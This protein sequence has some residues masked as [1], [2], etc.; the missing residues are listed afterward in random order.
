MASVPAPPKERCG[1]GRSHLAR[2]PSSRTAARTRTC[3]SSRL[4]TL[5]TRARARASARAASTSTPCSR[6]REAQRITRRTLTTLSARCYGREP[7]CWGTTP[8]SQTW[9]AGCAAAS[10][11]G[12]LRKRN[13][14]SV[15]EGS[16][17]ATACPRAAP[18]AAANAAA[19]VARRDPAAN[20]PAARSRSRG[21][22]RRARLRR[23]A[24]PPTMASSFV[25]PRSLAYATDFNRVYKDGSTGLKILLERHVRCWGMG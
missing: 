7:S 24:R 8:S 17:A 6:S 20:V 9:R 5:G 4:P 25:R 19:A 12:Y 13:R 18:R 22:A 10:T 15:T 21:P 1:G 14:A 16:P 3:T 2:T 23:A 11:P